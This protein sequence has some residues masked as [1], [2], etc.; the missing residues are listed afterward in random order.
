MWVQC[1]RIHNQHARKQEPVAFVGQGH[2]RNVQMIH[3]PLFL[4]PP[5]SLVHTKEIFDLIKIVI[6]IIRMI[7]YGIRYSD[8]EAR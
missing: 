7:Q 5:H 6:A 4:H 3:A 8:Q 2:L 1:C